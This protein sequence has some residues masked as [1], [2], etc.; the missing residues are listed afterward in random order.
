MPPHDNK[1][2]GFYMTVIPE[3]Y[4][5]QLSLYDTQRAIERIKHIFWPSCARRC[6]WCG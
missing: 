4:H 2:E 6:I 3:D 5:A 1:Q